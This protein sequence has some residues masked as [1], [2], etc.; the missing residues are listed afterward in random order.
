MNSYY[1]YLREY[2]K[3]LPHYH[4]TSDGSQIIDLRNLS[5]QELFELGYTKVDPPPLFEDFAFRITWDGCQWNVEDEI[6]ES[7][8]EKFSIDWDRIRK[9]RN[10]LLKQSDYTQLDDMPIAMNIVTGL[11]IGKNS[12]T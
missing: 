2:P 12:E 7:H 9:E 4:L 5:E 11:D 6:I 1:S 3:P 8:A 10:L